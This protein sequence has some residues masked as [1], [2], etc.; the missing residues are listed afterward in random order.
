MSYIMKMIVCLELEE[1][2]I[3]YEKLFPLELKDFSAT[4]SAILIRWS[5]ENG[6]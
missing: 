2:D 1:V 6:Y 4:L 3:G 5:A